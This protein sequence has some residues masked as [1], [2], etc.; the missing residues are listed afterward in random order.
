VSTRHVQ[1]TRTTLEDILLH[2]Q[3]PERYLLIVYNENV[4]A[5]ALANTQLAKRVN[6]RSRGMTTLEVTAPA[7]AK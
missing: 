3:F 5:Y 4:A 2:S 7:L 6:L 1:S